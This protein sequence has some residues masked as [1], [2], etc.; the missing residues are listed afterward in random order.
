MAASTNLRLMD[1][2]SDTLISNLPE[3][4]GTPN[5][6]L[7]FSFPKREYGRSIIV[8]CSFQSQWFS[9]WQWLHYDQS[10]DMAFC[11]TCMMAVKSK[12]ITSLGTG[13]LAFVS[14]GYSN[15]KDATG[16]K[17]AFNTHQKSSTHKRAV[18]VMFTLPATTGNVGEMSSRAHAQERLANRDNL[19][20]LFQNI[21]FLSRQGIA[22]RGHDEQNSNFIQLLHLRSIDDSKIL[23]YL[24]SK[25]DKY[26]S[27]QNAE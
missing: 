10:R 22:L 5:Q 21:Q 1:L 18:E 2:N 17:G 13:D 12:K 11:H 25:T 9:K 8:K 4:G 16:E 3:V 24:A 15:W 14:R 6:L 23:E 27:H 7:S 26:T 19:L 20:K